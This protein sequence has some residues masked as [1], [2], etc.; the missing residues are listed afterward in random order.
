MKK[1]L[2]SHE[3][4]KEISKDFGVNAIGAVEAKLLDSSLFKKWQELGGA[5]DLEY[6]KRDAKKLL[7]IRFSLK[8]KKTKIK[9]IDK[10]E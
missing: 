3:K 6:L 5:A 4:I 9:E 7:D 10:Y 1:L 8:N 2:F